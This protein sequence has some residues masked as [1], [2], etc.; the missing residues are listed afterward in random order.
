[1]STRLTQEREGKAIE[2]KQETANVIELLGLK[3]VSHRFCRR[4]KCGVWTWWQQQLGRIVTATTDHI[5]AQEADD[6]TASYK[7]KTPCS[8]PLQH[9]SVV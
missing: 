6:V 1:M 3:T 9:A 8:A 4:M 5:M 2:G 7:L